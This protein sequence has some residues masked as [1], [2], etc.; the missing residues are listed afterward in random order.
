MQLPIIE[1]RIHELNQYLV[2][3]PETL[4]SP[5]SF[6]YNQLNEALKPP[7]SFWHDEVGAGQVTFDQINDAARD[8]QLLG[9]EQQRSTELLDQQLATEWAKAAAQQFAGEHPGV[10]SVVD[11]LKAGRQFEASRQAMLDQTLPELRKT[12]AP[13]LAAKL[14]VTLR[15]QADRPDLRIDEYRDQLNQLSTELQLARSEVNRLK[16][17]LAT[18]QQLVDEG[19]KGWFGVGDTLTPATRVRDATGR[20][21]A[22]T[23]STVARLTTEHEQL[24]KEAQTVRKAINQLDVPRFRT[25]FRSLNGT[26]TV[27]ELLD[28]FQAAVQHQGTT[29]P[30]SDAERAAADEYQQLEIKRK[31]FQRIHLAAQQ[32][33]QG[34]FEVF[35]NRTDQH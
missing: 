29:D 18:Q 32:Q 34:Q 6:N 3:L 14:V 1:R 8:R 17:L 23:Q 27:G 20:A 16:R 33:F 5:D 11:R 30:V 25:L 7:E 21:L 31:E 35:I 10:A 9:Q 24:S 19:K 12:V 22:A 28:R 15:E 4:A 13:Y 2:A 26:M